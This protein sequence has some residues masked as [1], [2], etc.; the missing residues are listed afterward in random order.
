MSNEVSSQ[1]QTVS[2]QS[3]NPLCVGAGDRGASDEMLEATGLVV[4]VAPRRCNCCAEILPVGEIEQE[5]LEAE[6]VEPRKVLQSPILPSKSEVEKH[7]V[8]HWPPR[9]WC[10]D[11]CEGFGRERAHF[12]KP[13]TAICSAIVSFDYLFV[14]GSGEFAESESDVG[15]HGIKILVVKDSKSRSVFGHVVPQKGIDPK[16]FAVDCIVEDVM[17][18]GYSQVLL[19]SDNEPAITK[20]LKESLGACKVSGLEQVGEEHP[21]RTTVNPTAPLRSPCVQC[22]A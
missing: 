8:D 18:L 17:R 19:K 4:C 3:T 21:P 16:R 2:P 15:E 12:A 6:D 1:A 22:A 11:C 5:Q 7:R 9:D 13:D 20:L 10:D 14:K